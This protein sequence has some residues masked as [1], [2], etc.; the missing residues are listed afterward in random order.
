MNNCK[1]IVEKE[2]SRKLLVRVKTRRGDGIRLAKLFG[3][4]TV[5]VSQS[6]NGSKN[7]ELA[8]KIREM[9]VKIGGDGIYQ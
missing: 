4:T 2:N 1:E 7:S 6:V 5:F 3:V 8:K 9:A